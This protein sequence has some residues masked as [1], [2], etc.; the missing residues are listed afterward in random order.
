MKKLIILF[1]LIPNM[2]IAQDITERSIK[3]LG[4]ANKEIDPDEIELT[5]LFVETENVKK[6]NEL[7]LKEK[8]LKK[9]IS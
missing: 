1:A 4:K 7:D 9:L 6:K 5:I 3:V 2:I 8:E